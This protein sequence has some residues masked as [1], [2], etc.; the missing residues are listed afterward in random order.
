L[1]KDDRSTNAVFSDGATATFLCH[2]QNYG[3]FYEDHITDG[4]KRHYLF[5]SINA[6]ENGGFLHMSGAEVWMFTKLYVVPQIEKAFF[7]CKEKRLMVKGVYIHQASR[8]VVE[9][10]KSRFPDYK[11]KF[12]ENYFRY[13][14]TVSSSIPFC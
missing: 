4:S 13:G 6:N 12:Y 14:N 8:V 11:D 10:I 5:Q 7:F 3:I 2:N 1:S 9:G